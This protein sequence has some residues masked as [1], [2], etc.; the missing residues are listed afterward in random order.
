V[1]GYETWSFGNRPFLFALSLSAL[2]HLFWFFSVT[3]SVQPPRKTG[4]VKPRIVSLGP[5]IDDTIFRM[6]AEEKP[7]LSE[8]FYRHLDD[9]APAVEVKPQ[10]LERREPG[11]VV[12][13]SSRR[14]GSL[15]RDLIGGLKPAPETDLSTRVG[16]GFAEEAGRIEGAVAKRAFRV[17]PPLTVPVQGIKAP[18][19]SQAMLKFLVSPAGKVSHVETAVSSGSAQLDELWIAWIKRWEFEP[20]PVGQPPLEEE[21]LVRFVF[22]GEA[23]PKEA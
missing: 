14:S 13:L 19:G 8:T 7:Q 22:S 15:V 6:L 23:A 11:E 21:G 20:L 9:F 12:S 17:K 18:E 2:W 1:R 10:V 5:V 4:P 3:I 16:L